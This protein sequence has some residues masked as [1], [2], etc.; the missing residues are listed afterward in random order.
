MK[1]TLGWLTLAI[2][3]TACAAQNATTN[4][5]PDALQLPFLHNPI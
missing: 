3:L 5:T 2:L 1:Q 4:I